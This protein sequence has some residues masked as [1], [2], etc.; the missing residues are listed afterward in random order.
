MAEFMNRH[1]SNDKCEAAVIESRW[2]AG[3]VCPAS[4]C[5]HSGSFRREGQRYFACT[6]C[7]H[8]CSVISGTIFEA[9]KLGLSRWFLA[10]H[11]PTRSKTNVAVLELMCQPGLC[12]KTAWL[13]RGKDLSTQV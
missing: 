6:A 12:Y 1:G 13:T 4:G 8:Q 3:F 11:L 2:P 9:C 5:G 10:M 7:C